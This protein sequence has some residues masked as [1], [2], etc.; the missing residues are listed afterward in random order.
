MLQLFKRLRCEKGQALVELAFVIPIVLLF[1]FGIIDFGLALN[2]KNQNTN[3]ANI[4]VR[5]AAVIGTTSTL[6]CGTT[7]EYYLADWTECESKATG[8]P[9]LAGVCVYDTASSATGTTYTTGDPVKVKVWTTFGWLKLISGDS[10]G[11]TTTISANATM[12]E[13]GSFSAPATNSFLSNPSVDP[14]SKNCPS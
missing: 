5:E 13:E 12:R 9:T 3:I 11:L 2:S 14:L 6:T 10:G 7:T 4:S 8:G 1:L